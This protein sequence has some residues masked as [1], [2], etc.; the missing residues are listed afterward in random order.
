[1]TSG[2]YDDAQLTAYRE[3]GSKR[4]E[5]R[6]RNYNTETNVVQRI[7]DNRTEEEARH[8]WELRQGMDL[9]RKCQADS[10]Y[11]RGFAQK[12]KKWAGDDRA[13]LSMAGIK[14]LLSGL[15]PYTP[16][17]ERNPTL[18]IGTDPGEAEELQKHSRT[19]GSEI[20]RRSADDQSID[21]YEHDD[22]ICYRAT[23]QNLDETLVY[24]LG[25]FLRNMLHCRHVLFRP[26]YPAARL[27]VLL[28]FVVV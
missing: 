25:L 10:I 2:R 21:R 8:D 9:P 23:F 28:T 19:L 3:D 1:M 18:A 20:T 22:A 11:T 6:Q 16:P 14:A 12:A 17:Q 26:V 4:Y 7:V 15:K 13:L 27:E 24:E 5:I